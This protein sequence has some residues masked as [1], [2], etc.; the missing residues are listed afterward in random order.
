[1]IEINKSGKR[2]RNI[3]LL[4][5]VAIISVF[6]THYMQITDPMNISD[7][8]KYG[9]VCLDS[10]FLISGYLLTL[11]FF[12]NGE[13]PNG[14]PKAYYIK[15]FFRIIPTYLFIVLLY[16]FVMEPDK[17]KLPFW[18]YLLFLHNFNLE[19]KLI[20][21]F[22]QS[23]TIAVEEQF[24]MSLP[25]VLII[26]ATGLRFRKWI[27]TTLVI[28]MSACWFCRWWTWDTFLRPFIET[29]DY[30]TLALNFSRFYYHPT[31]NNIDNLIVGTLLGITRL[32]YPRIFER[33]SAFRYPF[34]FIGLLL[35]TSSV[36]FTGNM[37]S[38][39][40]VTFG[41]I[42]ACIGLVLILTS[43]IVR[44][45][46]LTRFCPDTSFFSKLCFQFYLL[47][48]QVIIL[49]LAIFKEWGW[50]NTGKLS[51]LFSILLTYVLAL[52]LYHSIERPLLRVRNVL[53]KKIA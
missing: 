35:A 15:R 11:S 41:K 36:I 40:F 23:W 6:Y 1:M 25:L 13:K 42:G 51:F 22:P 32:F 9:W 29:Q 33:L 17:V 39:Y 20:T 30:A 5:S 18:Q 21:F 47:H 28:T 24:Y 10:F 46:V 12:H 26:F 2:E 49:T 44:D 38:V 7:T 48:Y 4:R 34:F 27:I 43:F 37:L 52:A 16:W 31:Y 45:G 3:D 53:L 19:P 14:H 50:E 8:M